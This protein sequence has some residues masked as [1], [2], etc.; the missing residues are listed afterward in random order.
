MKSFG[1]WLAT[2][3]DSVS[4]STWASTDRLRPEPGPL[5]TRVLDPADRFNGLGVV[6]VPPVGYDHATSFRA[7]YVLARELAERGCLVARVDP[8]GTGDSAGIAADVTALN[9]WNNAVREGAAFVR[10]S[11][12]RQV[13]L[14]G[15]RAG[16]ALALLAAPSVQ[17]AAV[18]ALDPVLSG[19]RYV[20]G[21]QVMGQDHDQANVGLLV[22]GTEFPRSLLDGLAELD[23]GRD[24]TAPGPPCLLVARP[25]SSAESKLAER[26]TSEGTEAVVWSSSAL[27]GFL[28]VHAEQAEIDATFT[29]AVADWACRWVPE[30]TDADRRGM[31]DSDLRPKTPRPEQ[32]ITSLQWGDHLVSERFVTVGSDGLVGILTTP[33]DLA[34]P[35]GDL[36]VFLNS[37][38]EPHTGP[39]RA[40]VE[41]GR[42]LAGY[43]IS[44]LRVDMRGWG[45]SPD[46]PGGRYEP[47]HPYDPHS[48]DDVRQIVQALSQSGWDR[49]FLSGLC[50]GAWLAL[51][52]ARDTKFGGVLALNPSLLYQLGDPVAASAD[53]Y[54]KLFAADIA[55]RKREARAGRW[56]R[57][58]RAG[59][60]PPA[61][62]WLDSLVE[63]QMPCSLI[64]CEDD[65]GL[66]YLNDRLALRM[67]A[68]QESGYVRLLEIPDIDHSM[69]RVWLRWKVVQRFV[70]ELNH[71]AEA[72]GTPGGP[73]PSR[74]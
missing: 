48:I 3:N 40:W 26:L 19:R 37:G 22:G 71:W 12:A 13:L 27:E 56:D 54:R 72:V 53:E 51:Y 6:V 33:P 52:V 46:G 74:T 29:L 32:E 55:E 20:R 42:D 59:L 11:G 16:A 50:A 69:H 8:F 67:A 17:A 63:N 38:A 62:A 58:D 23:L 49:I 4:A 18:V 30:A 34:S 35:S 57:E 47:G 7:L 9:A 70:E 36:V 43:R 60:R 14:L 61:G 65:V 1:T 10:R 45:D 31:A 41:Y 25:S 64:F 5:A 39:A 44:S 66:E 73:V 15:C 2:A 28:G 24:L 68:V 21:L